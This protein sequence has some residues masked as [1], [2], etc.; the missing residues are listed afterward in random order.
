MNCITLEEFNKEREAHD[1][2]R[3]VLAKTIERLTHVTGDRD[4]LHRLNV[5]QAKRIEDMHST[6]EKL[7]CT[8]AVS[9]VVVFLIITAVVLSA[10]AKSIW[11]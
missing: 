7:Q 1:N 4:L 2:T 10:A 8:L 5:G 6:I 9:G 11:R 3:A